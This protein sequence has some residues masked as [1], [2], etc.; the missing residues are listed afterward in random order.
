MYIQDW[1][2]FPLLERIVE[3]ESYIQV[4]HWMLKFDPLIGIQFGSFF[5]VEKLMT[6]S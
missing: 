3:C 1:I 2:I 5:L 6:I 4:M